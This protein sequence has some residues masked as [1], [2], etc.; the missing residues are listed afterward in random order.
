MLDNSGIIMVLRL[1]TG[2]SFDAAVSLPYYIFGPP[3]R[4]VM[5][6]SNL[7]STIGR[8]FCVQELAMIKQCR[9]CN[10]GFSV[11]PSDYEKRATC[12]KE[13]KRIDCRRRMAGSGNHNYRN[14]G[15]HICPQCGMS[16]YRNNKNAKYCSARCKGVAQA[17]HT[18]YKAMGRLRKPRKSEPKRNCT[19]KECGV[20][21][22]YRSRR[23]YC[24]ECTR[25]GKHPQS[26]CVVCGAAFE[27]RIKKKTC[28]NACLNQYKAIR[29]RGPQSHRWQGGKTN[30]ATLLRN[31]HEYTNWRNSVYRRDDYTCQMCFEKGGKLAAHHIRPFSKYPE[32]RIDT[33]NG[34]TLC[35]AC[36]S[37]IKGREREYE[38]TFYDLTKPPSA[39]K[40]TEDEAA[41]VARIARTGA[42]VHVVT[43]PDEALKAI[44]AL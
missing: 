31:S 18:D 24:D 19:C 21:F 2:A 4:P 27:H 25:I 37:G 33:T 39:R 38:Q 22:V 15:Q 1:I 29:Q 6:L 30:S 11:K 16:F 9:I 40:L 17:Q 32:L 28:S 10:Q 43:T 7:H 36:H 14:A 41:T 26:V 23:Q 3:Y 5:S 35:W 44:G 34:I 20:A 42:P 12:S 8:A 13:C